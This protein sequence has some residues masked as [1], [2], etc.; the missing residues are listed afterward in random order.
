VL[1]R[2]FTVLAPGAAVGTTKDAVN[3]P[4]TLLVMT[5]G[6]VDITTLSKVI[7]IVFEARKPK[8]VT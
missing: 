2:A 1:S 7:E 4:F 6:V 8:P 3:P 5:A